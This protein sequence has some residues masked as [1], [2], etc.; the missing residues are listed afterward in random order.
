MV[1]FND[2]TVKLSDDVAIAVTRKLSG[3][4]PGLLQVYLSAAVACSAPVAPWAR[5][6]AIEI[7]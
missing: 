7:I 5:K 3:S 4:M 6:R 2:S 1:Q